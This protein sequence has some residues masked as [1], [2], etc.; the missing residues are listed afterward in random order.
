MHNNWNF[1]G[2][3]GNQCKAS[4]HSGIAVEIRVDGKS[5]TGQQLEK[6]S[7]KS[8]HQENLHQ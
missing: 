5:A 3:A 8:V 6:V 4:S 2:N 7:Q 1:L